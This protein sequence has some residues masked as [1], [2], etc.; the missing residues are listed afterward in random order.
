MKYTVLSPWA[1]VDQSQL[2]PLSPR[3]DT[4]NGK[5]IGMF[6]D[7][8]ALGTYM[9]QVVE[10]ELLAEYPEAKFSYFRY[11]KETTD[12][13]KD[14]SVAQE[15]QDWLAGVDCVLAFYGA[16]PS[17][18]LFLGYNAAHMERHGKPTVMAVV[19]RTLSAAQRGV[20]ARCVPGLRIVPYQPEVLEIFGKSSLEKTRANMG[21]TLSALVSDLIKG[22]TAPLTPEEAQPTPAP[23]DYAT[24]TYT[25]TPEELSDLF[26]H[27]GWTNGT[28]IGLPTR[29][30]VDEMLRG[31][32][33]P[34]DYVVAKLPPM[35]GCATVEKIAVNAV[36]AGCLPTYLPVL[37]AAVEGA[38]DPRIYLEGWS[39][40]QSTWGPMLTL[41]GK[42]AE[43]IGLNTS[44]HA[45]S[46]IRRANT[47]IARAFGYI[48]MNIAGLRPGVEDLSEMGHEFRYGYCI[49]ECSAASP[50]QPLHTDFG[51]ESE[52]SAVVLFW[53]QE[54]RTITSSSVQG[55]LSALCKIDPYGWDPGAMVVFTPKC[56]RLLAD[57]GW[58]KDRI[59]RYMVEYA[60]KPASQVDLAWLTMNNHLP[61]TADLPVN[62]EHSTRIFWSDDHMFVLVAG[63]MAGNMATIY[64]GG[65]DHGG[66]SCARICLPANWDALV[67]E[68]QPKAKPAY[69]AY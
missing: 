6:G 3:P 41:S 44:D 53:P 15:F 39:C 42:V 60:R 40:S 31:T 54:H 68:Y 66:P 20:K 7:F 56:A 36:M 48:L 47:T 10:A 64:A 62:P 58:T 33:L 26:Y 30:A 23:Q 34:R 55:V 18:A 28:P 24:A 16:V 52:D 14:D 38:M 67:A 5:T 32:D 21:D 57:A 69:L 25:G 63:G 11:H 2:Y 13:A 45:L 9:L 46:P 27:N 51:L 29:E 17:S 4:L 22:L 61:P 50:W 35:M 37:I 1:E 12:I 59:L 65:G 49:G 43:D 19:P 8:M